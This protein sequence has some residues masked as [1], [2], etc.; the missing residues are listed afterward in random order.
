MCCIQKSIYR[1]KR[2]KKEKHKFENYHVR[3]PKS[4]SKEIVNKPDAEIKPIKDCFQMFSLP[5][6]QKHEICFHS[7][8]I[9]LILYSLILHEKGNMYICPA[10]R[11]YAERSLK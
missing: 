5:L 6:K 9:L 1:N 11:M 3:L 7:P 4:T 8:H 2:K 10:S